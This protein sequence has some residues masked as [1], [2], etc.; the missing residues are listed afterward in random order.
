M[1]PSAE[2]D[3]AEDLKSIVSFLN[4]EGL[5]DRRVRGAETALPL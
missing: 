3:V 4:G 2:G 1:S 5:R